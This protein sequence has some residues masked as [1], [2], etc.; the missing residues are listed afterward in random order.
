MAATT[1]RKTQAPKPASPADEKAVQAIDETPA[2]AVEEKREYKV[3]Q[4]LDPHMYVTVKNGF[5]GVLVYK[6]RKTGERF[7]WDA[8]GDEQDMELAELKYAKNSSK[9]FFINNWFLFDDP[10]IVEWLG[11]SRYYKH[12]LNSQD[13]DGLFKKTPSE[14]KRILSGLSRGQKSSVAFRAKQLIADGE[15]DSIKTINALEESL[16]VE[17]IER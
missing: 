15:I 10:E 13:F 1:N 6:S 17:L 2:P 11:V 14:I 16:G 8:F 5:N 3:K 7:K 4:E 9:D 12:A